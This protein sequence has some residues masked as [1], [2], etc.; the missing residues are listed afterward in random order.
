MEKGRFS[1]RMKKIS[2]IV[3]GRNVKVARKKEGD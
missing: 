2:K 1:W 3:N